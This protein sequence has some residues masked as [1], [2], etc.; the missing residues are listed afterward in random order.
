MKP[1]DSSH[2][3]VKHF[4]FIVE[5]SNVFAV[6][7]LVLPDDKFKQTRN[8]EL[9]VAKAMGRTSIRRILI[10]LTAGAAVYL[11]AYYSLAFFVKEEKP[12]PGVHL[13]TGGTSVVA[14][15]MENRWRSAYR[16]EKEVVVDYQSTGSTKG[17]QEMLEGRFAIAFTHAPLT[18]EQRK[19]AKEKRGE[20]TQIPVVLCAVVPIYNLKELK[21]KPPLRFNGEV[22][23][24]IY[25]GKID[26][27]ND[28]ALK[29]LNPDAELPATKIAVIHRQD[30]SGTTWLFTD[31]LHRVSEAWRK[32]IGPPANKVAWKVGVG[33]ARNQ[34]VKN[35]VYATEGA[36]GYV[37]LIH[38]VPGEVPYGAVENHDRTAFIHPTAANMTAAVTA[39]LADIPQDLTFDLTNKAGK[40]AYP[41]CGVIWAVCYEEQPAATQ[42]QVVDF[43]LW[44]THDGQRFATDMAYAPLPPEL[45][46]RVEQKAKS[47]RVAP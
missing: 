14:I 46:G 37:D 38:A 33:K 39:Q 3:F 40:D 32:E 44:A 28:A 31:Y 21:G 13:E 5:A 6:E 20:V 24:D 4:R 11:L 36:I 2:Y 41:I 12:V 18:E 27:W 10:F 35:E 16:K 43:L 45:V 34:G 30:S 7:A 47:I 22:L 17:V 26:Q 25:L 9:A 29:K 1:V 42:R 19:T 15:M 8:P 23:A